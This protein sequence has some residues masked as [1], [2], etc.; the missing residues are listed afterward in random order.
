MIFTLYFENHF[1]FIHL[2]LVI[3]SSVSE[4]PETI[5]TFSQQDIF[6]ISNDQSADWGS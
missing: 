5:T 3:L 1:R 4:E 6:L 2:F